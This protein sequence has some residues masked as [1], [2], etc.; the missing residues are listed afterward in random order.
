VV[1]HRRVDVDRI[2]EPVWVV[3]TEREI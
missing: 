2:V 1:A 3:E